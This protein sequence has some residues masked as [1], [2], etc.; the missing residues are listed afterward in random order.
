MRERADRYFTALVGSRSGCEQMQ[1]VAPLLDHLVGTGEDRRRHV[2]AE[3]F[4][5][6]E[7]NRQLVLG[8]CLHRKVWPGHR[9]AMLKRSTFVPE[10]IDFAGLFW[11]DS[12]HPEITHHSAL[13]MFD[14]VTVQHPVARIVSDKGT[15]DL[16]LWQEKHGVRVMHR[17]A[18]PAAA[19]DLERM[20]VNMDRMQEW[21][22]V[23][24][25]E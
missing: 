4:R 21:R 25:R 8:R 7:V 14:D 22:C 6:L 11:R 15:L 5:R 2:E 1:Q 12:G 19:D 16:L 10:S 3:R 17:Q 18:L 13:L 9:C 23:L 24:Q 20:A